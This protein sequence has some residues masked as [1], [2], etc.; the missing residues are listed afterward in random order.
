VASAKLLRLGNVKVMDMYST[1]G[2]ALAVALASEAAATS[3]QS[4]V[5]EWIDFASTFEQMQ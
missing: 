4:A 5:E 2:L 1:Q 3:V